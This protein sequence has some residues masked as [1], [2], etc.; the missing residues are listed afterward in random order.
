MN[1]I[2]G[3]SSGIE[4]LD[5]LLNGL[6][7]GDN[8]VWHDDSGSLAGAF[9]LNFIKESGKQGK[10]VIYVT[11]D[12][13]PKICWIS[14]V[15]WPTIR[16]GPFWT[17]L[18]MARE[19]ARPLPPGAGSNQPDRPGGH[20]P[21]R[22]KGGHHPDHFEGGKKGPDLPESTISIKAL[23]PLDH[24]AGAEPYLI[25]IPAGQTLPSHFFIHKGDEVGC[26]LSGNLEFSLA[27][28]VH[29][30]RTGDVIYL[31]SDAPGQWRNTGTDAVP[32]TSHPPR[33]RSGRWRPR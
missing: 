22:S 31:T 15:R 32:L 9:R 33:L 18:P 3:V 5:K 6:Y 12:R 2:M 7:I 13:S 14:S 10:P 21:V 1:D 23:T 11:F 25:E 16:G 20:Q 27:K 19:K 17:A 8:V 28:T 24:N 26:V 4:P 30:A 29:T